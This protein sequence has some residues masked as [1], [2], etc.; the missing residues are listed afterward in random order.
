M[1]NKDLCK[2]LARKKVIDIL[3]WSWNDSRGV[4]P[5][6]S[7]I[8]DPLIEVDSGPKDR[9]VVCKNS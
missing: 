6:R 2:L 4:W 9:K 8:F 5:R 1:I 3:I 7:H